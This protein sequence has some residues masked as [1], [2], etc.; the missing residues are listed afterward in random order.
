MSSIKSGDSENILTPHGK[1]T[2]DD[3]IN[4]LKFDKPKDRKIIIVDSSVDSDVKLITD[5]NINKK[6]SEYTS[7]DKQPMYHDILKKKKIINVLCERFTDIFEGDV[8][9][10]IIKDSREGDINCRIEFMKN[11]G[12]DIVLKCVFD[13]ILN[14][15]EFV[16]TKK[17]DGKDKMLYRSIYRLVDTKWVGSKIETG[18]II[19][20][21]FYKE[22]ETEAGFSTPLCRYYTRFIRGSEPKEVTIRSPT[23]R[24]QDV[25]NISRLQ[26]L[27]ENEKFKIRTFTE[28]VQRRIND[29]IELTPED[30]LAFGEARDLCHK[31]LIS[32]HITINPVIDGYITSKLKYLARHANGKLY[33]SKVEGIS[34][35]K[36]LY[37]ILP[38]TLYDIITSGWGIYNGEKKISLL[39]ILGI[40]NLNLKKWFDNIEQ[41]KST[42]FTFISL[43]S[44]IR[45]QPSKNINLSESERRQFGEFFKGKPIVSLTIEKDKTSANFVLSLNSGRK[46]LVTNYITKEI[47]DDLKSKAPSEEKAFENYFK[48][49]SINNILTIPK[50]FIDGETDV[51]GT[52]S[53]LKMLIIN[54]GKQDPELVLLKDAVESSDSDKIGVIYTQ[55][56]NREESYEDT[57]FEEEDYEDEK[58]DETYVA[59]EGSWASKA[60]AAASLPEPERPKLTVKPV[61]T[62]LTSP[63]RSV[64]FPELETSSRDE[65]DYFGEFSSSKPGAR[66]VVVGKSTYYDSDR[67]KETIE[68]LLR[69]PLSQYRKKQDIIV[70]THKE[71]KRLDAIELKDKLIAN[72]GQEK[73]DRIFIGEKL[74]LLLVKYLQCIKNGIKEDNPYIS[75]YRILKTFFEAK[76]VSSH[77]NVIEQA[78]DDIA[79]IHLG[80]N[81][82]LEKIQFDILKKF[83]ESQSKKLP[84]DLVFYDIDTF[85]MTHIDKIKLSISNEDIKMPLKFKLTKLLIKIYETKGKSQKSLEKDADYIYNKMLFEELSIEEALDSLEGKVIEDSDNLKEIE[86][87]KAE[88]NNSKS[89]AFRFSTKQKEAI[90]KLMVEKN[91]TTKKVYTFDEAIVKYEEDNSS[92]KKVVKKVSPKPVRGKF[93]GHREKY[94]KYKTKYLE[95][96]EKLGL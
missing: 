63:S 40:T 50:V 25:R 12:E 41:F 90:A 76:S 95:L 93:S 38:F 65:G 55:L 74:Y 82:C 79:K 85:N 58:Y 42:V 32:Q 87:R 78:L 53:P 22:G 72:W 80:N 92:S 43:Y 21:P 9:N 20:R 68:N 13:A 89:P 52:S 84:Y 62:T 26:A 23:M 11:V 59:K 81:Y 37:Y 66:T 47:I 57:K 70:R 18:K 88:F 30:K 73:Y 28:L 60:R 75:D 49:I 86:R 6:Q 19:F 61:K 44:H 36:D 5:D 69:E 31:N 34:C 3:A 71:Y 16:I 4:S 56:T 29:D 15:I 10:L 27:D 7:K 39:D 35:I 1:K 46:V 24:E 8:P 94:L 64:T 96:K 14:K 91:P 17:I 45:V 48:N 54:E 2:I 67:L 83:A 77:V 51:F 33:N